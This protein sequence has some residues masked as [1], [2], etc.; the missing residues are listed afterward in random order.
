ME[1]QRTRQSPSRAVVLAALFFA[2]A[3]ASANAQRSL[4]ESGADAAL[5]RAEAA[6]AEGDYKKARRGFRKIARRFSGTA[7]AEIAA[8]RSAPTACLGFSDLRRS[9]PS[10]NRLDVVLMGEAFRINRLHRF[11]DWAATVPEV[12]ASCPTLAVYRSA[13]NFRVA[14]LVSAKAQLASPTL[15]S[16]TALGGKTLTEMAWSG[17]LG[18]RT[19][20]EQTPWVVIDRNKVDTILEQA[21]EHDDRVLAVVDTPDTID[22]AGTDEVAFV[23]SGERRAILN[24]WGHAMAGLGDETSSDMLPHVDGREPPNVATTTD[25]QRVPWAHWIAANADGVGVHAGAV[26]SPDRAYRP[27]AAG[28][29]MREDADTYCRVCREA[30][31]LAM[32][33]FVDPIDGCSPQA[34]RTEADDFVAPDDDGVYRFSVDLVLPEGH[35]LEVR[36]YVLGEHATPRPV[37]ETRQLDRRNRGSLERIRPHAKKTSLDIRRR[38]ATFEWT[39]SPI[40][41]GRRTRVVCRVVDPTPRDDGGLGWVLRDEYG[42]L[43]SERGW[44]TRP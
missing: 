2:F 18:A 11:D 41:R 27:T 16:D 33:R 14:H 21:G 37:R 9:G 31:V 26:G 22:A 17:V 20:Q 23:S 24:E 42:L 3:S 4:D 39:P 44:W 10:S 19:L 13:F 32:Y 25:P 15:S 28:C 8:R 34:I 30:M 29:V 6:L 5:R 38:T 36:W 1:E 40:E 35:G 12:F 7:A 43:E